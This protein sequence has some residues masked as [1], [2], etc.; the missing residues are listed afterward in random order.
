M[1][2]LWDELH[3][4]T[5]VL[6]GAGPVKQ[7]LIDAWRT[8]LAS[9]REHDLPDPLRE[10]FSALKS[11]MHEAHATGGLSA[12]EA[13]VRKMSERDAAAFSA[14]ILEMFTLLLA[15]GE[16]ESAP[17]LRIVGSV[18]DVGHAEEDVPAFLSRA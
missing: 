8:H 5:Q 7:R 9:L 14:G 6:V 1:A 3:A 11:A 10:P 4:A 17:R 13:S 18:D 16:T 12:P 2:A 15:A